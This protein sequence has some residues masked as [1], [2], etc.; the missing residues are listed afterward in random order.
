MV[1][2][3]ATP[4][5]SRELASFIDHTLLKPDAYAADIRRFCQEA[6]EHGFHSVCVNGGRVALVAQL[7]TSTPVRT[8]AVV[9]FPLGA[10]SHKAKA[11]EAA[12]AISEG[13]DEIDMVIDIGALKEGKPGI[14]HHDIA[15]IKKACGSKL[16][17]VI[18]EACLLTD[19]EK[20]TACRL[21]EEAGA[22]FVKTSTGFSHGGATVEDVALLRRLVGDRL[23]VKASGGIRTRED[24]LKMIAAGATRIGAS[25]SLSIVSP[26]K[27]NLS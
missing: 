5:N 18:I 16:L 22:D 12:I 8:C 23:G 13:A 27:P 19:D 9:G 10:M 1:T 3:Q 21:A 25:A 2:L 17:K 11:A 20:A 6:I 4:K 24:A 15:A 26:D 14:V 7:L